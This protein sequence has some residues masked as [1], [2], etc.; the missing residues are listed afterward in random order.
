MDISLN[1]QSICMTSKKTATQKNI[2]KQS[3]VS[4]SQYLQ[5]IA[6][7]HSSINN[8]NEGIKN[9]S[10][11]RYL[12]KKKG[13]VFANQAKSNSSPVIGNK[14]DSISLTS[15]TNGCRDNFFCKN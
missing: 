7:L 14:T 3:G 13:R 2:L 1:C 15:K 9:D 6:S 8:V 12:N 4:Q 11:E 10:Y 5:N